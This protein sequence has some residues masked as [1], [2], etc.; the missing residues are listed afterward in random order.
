M[1]DIVSR[2]YTDWDKPTLDTISQNDFIEEIPQRSRKE[3]LASQ[4]WKMEVNVPV[5]VSLMRDKA[6]KRSPTLEPSG[7][8]RTRTLEV[9]NS[10]LHL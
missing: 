9:K 6:K 1:D 3:V 10:H 2:L 8:K 5:T 7:F 4:Y